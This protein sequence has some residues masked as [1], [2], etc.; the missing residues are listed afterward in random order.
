MK[1]EEL[2]LITKLLHDNSDKFYMNL[3]AYKMGF[4][5]PEATLFSKYNLFKKQVLTHIT[6]QKPHLLKAFV[7]YE[8][9]LKENLTNIQPERNFE[10]FDESV[11]LQNISKNNLRQYLDHWSIISDNLKK[12]IYNILDLDTFNLIVDYDIRVPVPYIKESYLLLY[13][14]VMSGKPDFE[15]FLDE[16]DNSQFILANYRKISCP[17]VEA[18]IMKHVTIFNDDVYKSLLTFGLPLK[19]ILKYRPQFLTFALQHINTIEELKVVLDNINATTSL[20][21]LNDLIDRFPHFKDVILMRIN[22]LVNKNKTDE[23]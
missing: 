4:K 23:R 14:N 3:S 19:V 20:K 7:S 16:F 8:G 18:Y 12:K 11:H 2:E 17:R 1:E 5:I 10:L 13:I 15:M 22:T 6:T 21:L 9:K